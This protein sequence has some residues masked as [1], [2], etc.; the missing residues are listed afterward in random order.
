[1]YKFGSGFMA[2]CY[3]LHLQ[4]NHFLHYALEK[5]SSSYPDVSLILE[6]SIMITNKYSL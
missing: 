2:N 4:L 1:M 3:V 6:E 5:T